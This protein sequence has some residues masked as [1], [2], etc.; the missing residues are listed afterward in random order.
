MGRLSYLIT[1]WRV[2]TR[3]WG[4]PL[5]DIPVASIVIV[6]YNG[7]A[8]LEP[9]L[10]ET[11]SQAKALGAEVI[12]VDN[13]STD[14]SAQLV[15]REFPGVV[16]VCNERN[17]GFAG[18]ANEGVRA[19]RSD[20]VVLLNNDA[21]PEA[22][23]LETLLRELEPPDVAVAAS[24]IDEAR[25]PEAY[26]LGTGTISVIGHPIS[27]VLSDP[28][29][30]FYATGTALAFKR[31][32]FPEPF[33]P[34]F[35]AYYE[36]TLLSWRARLRGY[37]VVRAV[38]SR[39][40]HLGGATARRQPNQSV[41]YWERNKLLTLLLCYERATLV[42]LLPLYVFDGLARVAEDIWLVV[43]G[44]PRRPEGLHGALRR[45]T[46]VLRAVAWLAGH[47]S[48]ITTRRRSI[49]S[50]RRLSDASITPLLSAKIFDDHAPTVG[51]SVANAIARLY[52]RLVGIK[53][54]DAQSS[55]GSWRA[56]QRERS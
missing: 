38:G 30:P 8:L 41:F 14:G 36:D 31:A 51:H 29:T 27:S 46:L 7:R 1:V 42:R 56:R 5:T 40:R 23:W 37:R 17:E 4:E 9:C 24:V 10:R 21:I 16:L 54:A 33:D 18:G 26:S 49:Q 25:Y 6:N 52:C 3:P 32:L 28:A 35:F 47:F 50:E 13:A 48:A 22:G 45:Y 11:L 53:T 12:L 39:V 43:R 34:L 15:R 2:E 55:G 20:S 44:H 19:A